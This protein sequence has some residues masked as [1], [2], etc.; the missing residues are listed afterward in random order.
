MFA[1][2]DLYVAVLVVM[3]VVQLG[4]VAYARR[5]G[6]KPGS[7]WFAALGV[8]A[9]AWV[10]SDA[11]GMS[12]FGSGLGR[13]YVGNFN[14]AASTGAAIAWI[15]FVVVYTGRGHWLTPLRTAVLAAPPALLSAVLLLAP[16]SPLVVPEYGFET[17]AGLSFVWIDA[18]PLMLAVELY[19]FVLLIALYG[20]ILRAMLEEGAPFTGQLA[21]VMGGSL[22]VL[23]GATVDILNLV[24]EPLDVLGPSVGAT[25]LTCS[26][27]VALYRHRL[28]R[29]VPAVSHL[30]VSDAVQ[31]LDD[32]V[33]VVDADGAVTR[34]N[35]TARAVLGL[36]ESDALGRDVRT[37]VPELDGLATDVTATVERR[38]RTYHVT[39]SDI[40]ARGTVPVG[41]TLLFRDVTEQE[42]REQRLSVLGRVL[43][44]NLRN[45]VGAIEA[46]ASVLQR[47]VE[48]DDL[49]DSAA[50]I[51]SLALGMADLGDK[52]RLAQETLDTDATPEPVAVGSLVREVVDR[53]TDATPA[54]VTVTTPGGPDGDLTLLTLRDP[55]VVA[56][57]NVL[58]NA[59]EHAG[60]DPTVEVSVAAAGSA[61]SAGSAGVGDGGVEASGGG[62]TGSSGTAV[63]DRERSK[64]AVNG[65]RDGTDA[66]EA[67]ADATVV[68]DGG[69]GD[70]TD[71]TD[72]AATGG[73]VEA[74]EI[75]VTDDGPGIPDGQVAV[76]EAGAETQHV[77]GD[78]IGLWL[79]HWATSTLR[80]SVTFEATGD[81]SRVRLQLP[82]LDEHPSRPP[83]T[84]RDGT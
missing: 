66:G 51:R 53:V 4:L 68:S 60:P 41:W 43:R 15:G 18:G 13:L 38:G 10:L 76:L 36:G 30:G 29:L 75:A 54:T 84:E 40:T 73:R 3:G 22:A 81:G 26:F 33:L 46:H 47:A 50:A 39:V 23:A 19:L 64:A 16:T 11:V 80:G 63:R 9:A 70:T 12:L 27:A 49:D 69:R 83:S 20:L 2:G 65:E 79:V 7:R 78:G 17:T 24:A 61:G 42:R 52:A 57:E 77:H 25:V 31:D 82:A 59:V 14:S 28:F 35:P 5:G 48:D 56:L 37:L 74:V 58:E 32:G 55:L 67:R 71:D 44:H 34:A 1:T 8:F 45:D 6:E 72:G 62:P 21:W